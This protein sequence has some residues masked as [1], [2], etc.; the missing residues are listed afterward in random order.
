MDLSDSPRTFTDA[1]SRSWTVTID[2]SN[3]DRLEAVTGASLIDLV[4]VS[5]PKKGGKEKEAG[6]FATLAEFMA[7]PYRVFEAFYVLIKPQS[8]ALGIDRQG[9]KAGIDEATAVKMGS[10]IM[11]AIHDFFPND[12]MRRAALRR[13]ETMMASL[14]QKVSAKIEKEM[15]KIDLD[16][17][18]DAMPTLDG[19]TAT[20]EVIARLRNSASTT[21]VTLAS[22]PAP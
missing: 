3:D 4:P 8:D 1:L 7:D 17:I 10:A 2:M 21:A 13:M 14:N 5:K 22:T 16:A 18:V 19:V 9:V 20:N 6:D 15:D 12:P 11:R